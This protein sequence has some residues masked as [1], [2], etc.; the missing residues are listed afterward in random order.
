VTGEPE[1]TAAGQGTVLWRLDARGVATVTLNRPRVNNAYNGDL[2]EGLH[3]TLDALG[4]RADLRAVVVRGAG[5][6]FQ[7]GADLRWVAEVAA[8]SPAENDRASRATAEAVRRLEALP[9]PT[10]ALI[11]GGCFGGGTG[12]V[13]ACDVA[14]AAE[15]AVFSVSETRW[16][17]MAG[18]ILPQL[19]RAMGPRHARRYAL[20]GE[21]FDAHEACRIGLVHEVCA[22]DALDA[23]GAAIVDAVLAG[24][25]RAT[26]ATKHRLLQVTG[27]DLGNG[28][29]G[30]L[31]REHAALRQLD[32][33]AQGLAAFR[34]KRSPPWV[35]G[36]R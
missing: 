35:P 5:R 23:R 29:F 8:Q 34:A 25:P 24:A 12:L 1:P 22:P 36:S 28:A 3:E 31:V 33:A 21:R 11:Q 18:I 9:V 4:A 19:S 7:A 20:T 2:I 32:E 13:A 6:H 16:G 26:A 14:V 15:D 27:A 10:L 30:D 17:L